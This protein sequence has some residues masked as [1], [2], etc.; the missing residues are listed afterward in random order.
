MPEVASPTRR[1]RVRDGTDESFRTQPTGA[2]PTTR[3]SGDVRQHQADLRRLQDLDIQAPAGSESDAAEPDRVQA[4]RMRLRRQHGQTV[5]RHADIE[6]THCGR[7]T[8]S[9]MRAP[10]PTSPRR[11]TANRATT[12]CGRRG[13]GCAGHRRSF[14]KQVDAR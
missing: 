4:C 13:R 6:A 14:A 9:V 7:R 3:I 2:R 5:I 12:E 8:E 11:V 1:T 10:G